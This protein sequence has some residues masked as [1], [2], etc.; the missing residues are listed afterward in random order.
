MERGKDGGRE[1]GREIKMAVMEN[2]CEKEHRNKIKSLR[3]REKKR[4]KE[5]KGN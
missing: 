2:E 4:K 5:E 3:M 1:R